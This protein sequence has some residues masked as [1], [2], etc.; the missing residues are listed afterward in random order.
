MYNN[1]DNFFIRAKRSVYKWWCIVYKP[2]YKLTH[3]GYWPKEKDPY[4]KPDNQNHAQQK[5]AEQMAMQVIQENQHNIDKIIS[6]TEDIS[7]N[8][9]KQTTPIEPEIDTSNIDTDVLNRANEILDRLAREANEDE[10]K[11]QAEIEKAKLEAQNNERIASIMKANQID[12]STY[13]EQGKAH[14]NKQD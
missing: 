5:L 9:P 3:K 6:H 14:Q 10:L 12:I 11:K 7:P 13:I 1:N 4:Y 2:V 8:P